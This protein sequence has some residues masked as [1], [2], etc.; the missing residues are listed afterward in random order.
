MM[1]AHIEPDFTL[2]GAIYHPR[3]GLFKLFCSATTLKKIFLR[4]HIMGT[5][6]LMALK[7]NLP[8]QISNEIFVYN[9]TVL[10]HTI[11]E[12]TSILQKTKM[13][14]KN[15]Q[16]TIYLSSYQSDLMGWMCLM[17]F[18]TRDSFVD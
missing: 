17:F 6:S 16:K 3:P 1:N 18:C 8:Y 15:K 12:Y 4:D 11:H 2:G 9:K 5:F 10:M 7:R 13:R 14:I